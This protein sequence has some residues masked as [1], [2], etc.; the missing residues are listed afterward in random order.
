MTGICQQEGVV[1]MQFKDAIMKLM[2]PSSCSLTAQPCVDPIHSFLIQAITP[3]ILP[4]VPSLIT[5]SLSSGCFPSSRRSLLCSSP[6]PGT[7]VW[8]LFFLFYPNH[9]NKLPKSNSLISFHRTTCP[10]ES[11]FRP[12]HSME[13]VLLS[14]SES[15]HAA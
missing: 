6:L 14:I 5:S 15:L 7:T 13:T 3:D 11:G 12:G 10:H 2:V 4:I 8:Y 1:P 9:L